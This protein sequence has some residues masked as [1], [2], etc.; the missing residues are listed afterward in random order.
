MI[1]KII[2]SINLTLRVL[3]NLI[4][5]PFRIAYNK[6]LH[7]F[8]AGKLATKLPGAAKKLPSILKTKPEKRE[9]YFDWGSVYVAKSLVLIV[10]L[11]LIILPLLIIFV[12]SPLC[13]RWFGVKR[14][15]VGEGALSSYSGKVQ[16]YYDE[17][18]DALW[19]EAKLKDGLAV[20]HGDELYENGRTKYSGGFEEGV[21]SGT[22]I[23]CYE[24]GAV[25]Y[26]GE[27]AKGVFSG[28]GELHAEDGSVYAGTFEK[29][30]LQGRGTLTINDALYYEGSF[31][32]GEINGDGRLL[33]PDGAVK[34]SGTFKDGVA[35]GEC[36]EYAEDGTL[37]YSG[38]FSAGV[39]NGAGTLYGSGGKKLYSG[40]F[41]RGKYSGTGTLYTESGV[42]LYSGGFEEGVYSGSGTLWCADGAQITGE[43]SQGE[44]TGT[45]IKS[46]PSGMRYEG[47]FSA[48]AP[49]GYGVLS[50]AVGSFTFTGE[51]ADGDIGYGAIMLA[52]IPQIKDMFGGELVQTAAEDCFYL[53]NAQAG[54][55]LRCSYAGDEP[56]AVTEICASPLMNGA[57]SVK[58]A[59]DIPAAGAVSAERDEN[60][61]LSAWAAQKYALDSTALVCYTAHYE[62]ADVCYW[63]ENG[64]LA[65]KTARPVAG[66]SQPAQESAALSDDEM[67]ALFEEL[68]L[69]IEDFRSLGF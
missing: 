4:Q 66:E 33:Y 67:A 5:R 34:L 54:I 16:V 39:Y 49:S 35:E 62:A 1:K 36:A 28:E 25:R 58:S 7:F 27:F 6:L 44:I 65:L 22:G 3:K 21:Y 45:A 42:K 13:I 19:L 41:E 30:L 18:Y 14:F 50:G 38:T 64:R 40:D 68:G 8:N 2:S 69:D 32:D 53:E 10:A 55:A 47:T 56:A 43:F 12:I 31:A 20:G 26:R 48:G 61:R 46:Y 29:G 17:D 60:A 37:K 24:D 52:D 15:V 11:V 59:A 51:F 23:L 63:V 9:D 57:L